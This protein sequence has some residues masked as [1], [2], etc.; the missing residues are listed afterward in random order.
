[1][2]MSL[3]TVTEEAPA[4]NKE[5]VANPSKIHPAHR[6]S[7]PRTFELPMTIWY[8][9]FA[10]YAVFFGALLAVTGRDTGTVF[11]IV[12][13]MGYAVMYFG[14]A[15]ILNSISPKT[16]RSGNRDKIDT[17]TGSLSLPAAYAQI[18]TV[19]ILVALFGCVAAI[20]YA[21]VTP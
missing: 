13:S 14:T 2:L 19:P 20:F 12:I 21:V 17:F 5:N 3:H 7:E 16:Q 9:M 4:A 10:S 15:A 11:V 8:S 6:T 18:L 1:M